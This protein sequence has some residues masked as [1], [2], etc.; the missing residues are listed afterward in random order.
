MN[1][2]VGPRNSS[3]RARAVD[4]RRLP[5]LY[6]I[7]AMCYATGRVDDSVGYAEAGRLAI[8][9]GRFDE[10]PYEFEVALSATYATAGA[11]RP[12]G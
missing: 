7:A 5:Q 4:H 8:E 6:V 2:W 1:P 10:V 12:V 3:N 9:S 11:A